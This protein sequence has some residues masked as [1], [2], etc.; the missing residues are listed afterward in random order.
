MSVA[1]A[2]L[3]P[4]RGVVRLL[5]GDRAGGLGLIGSSRPG[6]LVA[7]FLIPGLLLIPAYA[8]LAVRRFEGMDAVPD[9][10][11]AFPVEAVGYVIGWTAFPLAAH[12]LCGRWGKA[13]EWYDY[14]A[15]Y[16]WS[17]VLQMAFYLPAAALGD[18]DGLAP[19]TLF[20]TGTI[21]VAA[22][23]AVH[24]RIARVTLGVDAL[25]AMA[26]V[27]ADLAVGQLLTQIVDRLHGL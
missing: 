15:A 5:R 14:I 27:A 10:G 8:W 6:G 25:P 18:A 4:M 13:K 22:A 19:G 17:S 2:V 3:L 20:L 16:N 11:D 12:F 9:F 24:F 26:L 21:A 7:S 1:G 23:V